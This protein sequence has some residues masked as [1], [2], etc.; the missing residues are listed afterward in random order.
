DDVAAM[1]A[2]LASDRAAFVTGASIPVDGG[3]QAKAPSIQPIHRTPQ[4]ISENVNMR[5]DE[6]AAM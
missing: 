2:F 5:V 1:V 6:S 3:L 4:G